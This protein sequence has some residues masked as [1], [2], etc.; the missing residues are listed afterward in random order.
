V[1]ERRS[2]V[3]Q[4]SSVNDFNRLAV[5]E[6]EVPK[7]SAISWLDSGECLRAKSSSSRVRRN[8]CGGAEPEVMKYEY[9]Y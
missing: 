1:A 4:P 9:S 2:T 3:S 8:S 7:A 5:V 6:R